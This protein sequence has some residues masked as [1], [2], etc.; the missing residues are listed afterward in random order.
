MFENRIAI[1]VFVEHYA[2]RRI[3]RGR[4][5][6][7]CHPGGRER[8]ADLVLHGLARKARDPQQSAMIPSAEDRQLRTA[9]QRPFARAISPC[10]NASGIV[11]SSGGT[12]SSSS[13]LT[14]EK[15]FE[16]S[17]LI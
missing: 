17:I 9:L 1:L 5:P 13:A 7:L 8:I 12:S 4:Q 15:G 3:Q 11:G 10:R 14:S 6:V 16:D 2:Q